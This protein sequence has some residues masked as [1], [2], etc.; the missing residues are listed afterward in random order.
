MKKKDKNSCPGV[1]Y[2]AGWMGLR[3]TEK[4][5]TLG[6]TLHMLYAKKVTKV[7]ELN[8]AVKRR[9]GNAGGEA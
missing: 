6:N 2:S 7:V 8:Q 9:L 1:N 5:N 3:G 4:H